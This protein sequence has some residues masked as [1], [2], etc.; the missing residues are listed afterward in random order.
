MLDS[1]SLDDKYS[2]DLPFLLRSLGELLVMAS[3]SLGDDLEGACVH[4]VRPYLLALDLDV[5]AGG[6]RAARAL[7][8]AA[9][10]RPDTRAWLAIAEYG[11]LPGRGWVRPALDDAAH[12]PRT[13]RLVLAPQATLDDTDPDDDGWDRAGE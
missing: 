9:E 6:C 3:D 8:K 5:A 7:A 13:I 11:A 1:L 12:P 4:E 2:R 10:R